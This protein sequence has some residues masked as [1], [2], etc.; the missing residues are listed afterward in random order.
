MTWLGHHNLIIDY[1]PRNIQFQTINQDLPGPWSPG[2]NPAKANWESLTSGI[3]LRNEELISSFHTVF[4]TAPWA[5]FLENHWLWEAV[6]HAQIRTDDSLGIFNKKP[7]MK[8]YPVAGGWRTSKKLQ[9]G[10]HF[11]LYH[12]AA[13]L[14]LS[15][16]LEAPI[17]LPFP[18]SFIL[19]HLPANILFISPH[20]FHQQK[21]WLGSNHTDLSIVHI[22]HFR[23]LLKEN[24]TSFRSPVLWSIWE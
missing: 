22:L 10:P 14:P 9:G 19:S 18:A 16:L 6:F 11:S 8:V 5:S 21:T 1:A 23:V 4:T 2:Q 20:L 24:D 7:W 3:S 13:H 12:L 15:L 17:S